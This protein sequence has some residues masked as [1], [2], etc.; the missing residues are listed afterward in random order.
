MYK[1]LGSMKS[2][3]RAG[4][5]WKSAGCPCEGVLYNMEKQDRPLHSSVVHSRTITGDLM[6]FVRMYQG[7]YL[8]YINEI[9]IPYVQNQRGVSALSVLVI[10]HNFRAQTTTSINTLI[11]FMFSFYHQI[12]PLSSLD[13]AVNKSAK[14][15][16]KQIF[17]QSYSN[18][19][20]KQLHGISDLYSVVI[21]PVNFSMAAVKEKCL[22][23]YTLLT[24][25]NVS[26]F[27]EYLMCS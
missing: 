16:L 19:V 13:I 3:R 11:I 24:I 5:Q 17:E 9:I 15:F 25:H 23:A 12:Q 26:R 21:Q 8:K 14:D 22:V 27:L 4:G 7:K 20:T 2:D 6:P 1:H 10:M 18:K